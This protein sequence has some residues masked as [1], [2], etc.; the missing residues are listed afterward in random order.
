MKIWFQ[1]PTLESLNSL[2][3]ENMGG[4]LGIEFIEI[5]PDFLTAKMPVDGRTRQPYGYLHGGAS[6]V[7]AETVASVAANLCV[8]PAKKICFGLDI[9]TSHLRR[10]QSGYIFAVARPISLGSTIQVW[11]IEIHNN[12]HDLIAYSRLTVAVRDVKTL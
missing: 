5:G 12:E 7:L 11:V 1:A 10:V 4:F 3:E 6:C 2:G 8:D 9:N